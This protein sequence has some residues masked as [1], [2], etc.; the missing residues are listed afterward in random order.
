MRRQNK[1]EILE[2]LAV[3]AIIV[4]L[5]LLGNCSL[6]YWDAKVAEEQRVPIHELKPK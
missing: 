6:Q 2:E 4:I 1:E 5:L 3:L